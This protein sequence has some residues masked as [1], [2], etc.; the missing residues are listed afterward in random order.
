LAKQRLTSALLAGLALSGFAGNSLLCRLALGAEHIDPI[1]FTLLRIWSGALTLALIVAVSAKR[2]PTG[3]DWTSGAALL[4]YALLFSLAYRQIPAG[5][6]ALFLFGSVQVTMITTAIFNGERLNLVKT[7]GLLT[8]GAGLIVLLLPRFG[9]PSTGASI[10]MGGAGVAWGVYTLRGRSAA[11]PLDATAGNFMRAAMLV[12][13]IAGLRF[14]AIRVDKS[15]ALCAVL[16][17][18]VTSG[19]AYTIWYR[20]LRHISRTTAAALQLGVPILTSIAGIPLLG[21]P[22][23]L[24]MAISTALTL[25]GIAMVVIPFRKIH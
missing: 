24:D 6:G 8:A 2:Q 5:A 16:S 13:I 7:L 23:E 20:V 25:G 9:T 1:G 4:A 10:A 21:E 17:G 12:L 14:S 11:N 19:I 3:G 18:A 15:G 22:V